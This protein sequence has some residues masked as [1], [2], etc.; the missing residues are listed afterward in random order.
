MGHFREILV[1]WGPFGILALS[2]IESAGIPNPGGTDALLLF[3]TI[4]RPQDWVLC[5]LMAVLG[6]LIGTFFFYEITRKGGEK[7][8]IRYTSGDRGQRF[9]AWFQRYGLI[10]VLIPALIPI[11]V[12]PFKVFAACAGAM[13][14][15]RRKFFAV[16]AAGRIPRYLALGYLGSRLGDH[17]GQW[18]KS[19]AWHLFGIAAL[20]SVAL[21]LAIRYAD[22]NV[23]LEVQT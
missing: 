19:H 1:S 23:K 11:P 17:A 2:T 9:Q 8:L 10:T 7:L 13:S 4:S 20:L 22:R 12:L 14:V 5:A 3:I 6:S 15:P 16:L 18:L 21:Y